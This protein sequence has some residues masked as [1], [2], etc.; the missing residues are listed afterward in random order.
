MVIFNVGFSDF[1][2]LRNESHCPMCYST[3]KGIMPGFNNCIW[4]I[5]FRKT[6][7]I[8][9][10]LKWKKAGD[11]YTTYDEAQAGTAD[12]TRLIMHAKQLSDTREQTIVSEGKE[13]KTTE[14]IIGEIGTI[15]KTYRFE[16]IYPQRW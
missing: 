1:D 12:F 11:E 14:D 15:F 9:S 6:N 10:R 5:D 13:M 2:L 8:V 3:I 4:R 7:G 16:P